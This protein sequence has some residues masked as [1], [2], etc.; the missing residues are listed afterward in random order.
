MC[1]PTAPPSS[2]RSR[3]ADCWAHV[4]RLCRHWYQLIL[5]TVFTIQL[6]EDYKA[7]VGMFS[8][9]HSQLEM[10]FFYQS[11]PQV[12]CNRPRNTLRMFN[13][14]LGTQWPAASDFISFG[15]VACLIIIFKQPSRQRRARRERRFR[16]RL[17]SAGEVNT[18]TEKLVNKS[19]IV[20]T[21]RFSSTLTCFLFIFMLSERSDKPATGIFHI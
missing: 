10:R 14:Y 20:S 12:S 9:A 1:D 17:N 5:S 2:G 15:N 6:L 19:E 18:R 13:V 8:S 4:R 11:L 21:L 16:T 7:M 3:A